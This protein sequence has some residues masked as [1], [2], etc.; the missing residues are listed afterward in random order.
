MAPKYSFPI[1]FTDNCK[2]NQPAKNNAL[3][4][5]SDIKKN[6]QNNFSSKQLNIEIAHARELTSAAVNGV[7]TH[8]L[9]TDSKISIAQTHGFNSVGKYF[10]HSK[11]KFA[12]NINNDSFFDISLNHYVNSG[13]KPVC[14]LHTSFN[15]HVNYANNKSS[16][17][18]IN[19]IVGS[20][21]KIRSASIK[22]GFSL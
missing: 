6:D 17:L 21:G 15:K 9:S 5:F 1:I 4:K 8:E 12:H 2:N 16:N 19:A 18:S 3:L 13:K 10:R 22:C 20:G 11:F 7:Y 14:E